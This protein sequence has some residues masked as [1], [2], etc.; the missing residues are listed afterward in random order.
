KDGPVAAW[1]NA[2][3]ATRSFGWAFSD[4]SDAEE[5]E[6]GKSRVQK[7]YDALL[8]VENTTAARPISR[9]LLD[10]AELNKQG[11]PAMGKPLVTLANLDFERGELGKMPRDWWGSAAITG[12]GYE[13]VIS[14]EKAHD[15]RQ[16]AML[17]SLAGQHND[18]DFG[19]LFKMIDATPYQ[20]KRIRL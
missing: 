14:A 1:F 15:G 16:C 13:A 3:R 5:L 6:S 17:R 20:G 9:L 2:P 19:M 10:A 8:F 11:K 7:L 18:Y 12:Q 4:E